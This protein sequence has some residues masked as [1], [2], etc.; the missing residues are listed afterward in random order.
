MQPKSS[1]S[2]SRARLV[3]V[4]MQVEVEVEE[5]AVITAVEVVVQTVVAVDRAGRRVS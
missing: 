3:W 4:E 5:G 2:A 1:I